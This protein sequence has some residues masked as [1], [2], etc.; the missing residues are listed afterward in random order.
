MVWH[1]DNA[2]ESDHLYYPCVK[3]GNISRELEHSF[4][5][6]HLFNAVNEPLVYLNLRTKA[7]K[8]MFH[9]L[10]KLLKLHCAQF[11]VHIAFVMPIS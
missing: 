3:K 5:S 2:I 9:V 7:S 11:H 10:K 8:S 6:L 4:G 1:L